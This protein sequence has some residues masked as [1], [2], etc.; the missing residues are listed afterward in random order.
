MSV[1]EI[2]AGVAALKAAGFR[3]VSEF[4]HLFLTTDDPKL[5]AQVG[6]FIQ[7]SGFDIITLVLGHSKFAP[8]NRTTV[9]KAREFSE[10]FGAPLMDWIVVLL[11]SEIVK[12][13]K[14]PE[15]ILAPKDASIN[16]S[17]KRC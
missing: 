15:C 17:R 10:R 9:A 13:S 5:H 3:S 11:K 2:L 14:D 6:I 16:T 7:R 1:T 12:L 8:K 4:L